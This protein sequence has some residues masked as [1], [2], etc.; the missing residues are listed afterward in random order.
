MRRREGVGE[1]EKNRRPKGARAAQLAENPA[2]GSGTA[3]PPQCGCP[4]RL[5]RPTLRNN[6]LCFCTGKKTTQTHTLSLSHT[7]THTHTQAHTHPHLSPF[8]KLRCL[9]RKEGDGGN[10]GGGHFERPPQFKKKE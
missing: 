7:H 3:K 2:P 5:V 6:G 1:R 8:S 10:G 4:I 9:I